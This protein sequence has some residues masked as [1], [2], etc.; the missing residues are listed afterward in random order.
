LVIRR[1]AQLMFLEGVRDC[2][3][4]RERV[5]KIMDEECSWA[6]GETQLV[7]RSEV[8]CL[9]VEDVSRA[10]VGRNGNLRRE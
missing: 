4:E 10:T 9:D 6:N 8:L 2:V 1:D 7:E 3:C 5:G